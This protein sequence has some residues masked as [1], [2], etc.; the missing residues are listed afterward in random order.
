M[1]SSSREASGSWLFKMLSRSSTCASASRTRWRRSEGSSGKGS[2]LVRKGTSVMVKSGVRASQ[3]GGRHHHDHNTCTLD[4]TYGKVRHVHELLTRGVDGT[5][6]RPRVPA[7][8]PRAISH[9]VFVRVADASWREDAGPLPIPVDR[10]EGDLTP[11]ARKANADAATLVI[12]CSVGE[13][14]RPSSPEFIGALH[15]GDVGARFGTRP[16]TAIRS[17]QEVQGYD[18]CGD[19]SELSVAGRRSTLFRNGVHVRA[20]S[21]VRRRRMFVG[22]LALSA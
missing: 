15:A 9:H 22:G 16:A 17:T 14:L 1:A 21:P 18:F 6:S 4:L 3:Q 5:Y 10:S 19:M 12:A 7:I 11:R 2:E 20:V 13:R 8:R